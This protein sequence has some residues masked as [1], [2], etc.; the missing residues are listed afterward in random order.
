MAVRLASRQSADSDSRDGGEERRG[1]ERRGGERKRKNSESSD[2]EHPVRK[3][4]RKE[5]GTSR[6]LQVYQQE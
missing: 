2:D 6:E 1:E 5:W 4:C 3:G